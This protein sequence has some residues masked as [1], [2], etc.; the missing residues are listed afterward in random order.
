MD[1][2]GECVCVSN[3]FL[4]ANNFSACHNSYREPIHT[5]F[6]PEICVR[7]IILLLLELCFIDSA[8]I[9]ISK[10][11]NVTWCWIACYSVLSLSFFVRSNSVLFYPLILCPS[12]SFSF[13]LL[14][15]FPVC[16]IFSILPFYVFFPPLLHSLIVLWTFYLQQRI[17][18][19]LHAQ[20]PLFE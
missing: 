7:V 12:H 2:D 15:S 11:F 6:D 20:M 5:F 3:E 14:F 1:V 19:F 10:V 8:S 16:Y 13:G 18:K 9:F 17:L 4:S